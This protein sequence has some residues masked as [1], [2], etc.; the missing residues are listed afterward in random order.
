MALETFSEALSDF[1]AELA[2]DP[3]FPD[4]W[5]GRALALIGLAR[6]DEALEALDTAIGLDPGYGDAIAVKQAIE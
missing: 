2:L 6:V 4:A 5:F 3:Q 1:E